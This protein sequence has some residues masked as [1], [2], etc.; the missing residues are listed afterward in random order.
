MNIVYLDTRPGKSAFSAP[1]GEPDYLAWVLN[2]YKKQQYEDGENM[3][4]F[5]LAQKLNEIIQAKNNPSI[6]ILGTHGKELANFIMTLC[7]EF[8]KNLDIEVLSGR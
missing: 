2:R 5:G 4:C 8:G 3:C 7:V 6:V 1:V